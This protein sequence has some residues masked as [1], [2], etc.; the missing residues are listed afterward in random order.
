MKLR[1]VLAALLLTGSA[2]LFAQKEVIVASY[3]LRM[4]T[5]RD[6]INAWPNRKEQVRALVRYHDFD[7]VGTQ[8]GFRGQLEDLAE[9]KE[10]AFTG[11]GRDDGGQGGEHSAIFYRKD[12]FK[13]LASG[14]F[15][16]SET[17]DKPGKGWDATCCNR[18]ASWAELKDVKSKKTFYVFNVHFDHQGVIARRESGKL[19]VEKIRAIAGKSPVILTGDLNSTPETEQIQG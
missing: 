9:L 7:I 18:I 10:F 13:L 4:N 11:S 5:E 8:E 19:M 12:R 3:N 17:P 6:G 1:L 14:D 15:W 16:L 2:H